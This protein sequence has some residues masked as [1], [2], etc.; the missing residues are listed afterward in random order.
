MR[1]N[2]GTGIF[3]TCL[4]CAL[5][6]SEGLTALQRSALLRAPALLRQ[7]TA[8]PWGRT[9]A[10][11]LRADAASLPAEDAPAPAVEAPSGGTSGMAASTFNVI[12]NIVGAGMLSLPAGVAAFTDNT[13]GLLPATVLT[14]IFGAVSAY[15][16]SVLG[17]VTKLNNADSYEDAWARAVSPNSAWIVT[18]ACTLTCLFSCL[19]YGLII[20]DSFTPFAKELGLPALLASR[21]GVI[22]GLTLTVLTPLCLLKDLSALAFTSVLGVAGT[23][24]STIAIMAR[25]FDGSYAP[26]AP[27][28]AALAASG[29]PTPSFD[30]RGGSVLSAKAFV[31]LSMLGTAYNAHFN[32]PRFF[33][34]LK[35]NTQKR[36][37]KVVW[38]SFYVSSAIYAAV[39]I[40]GF[41]TFGGSSLG[42]L[43]NNYA[44]NDAL[45]GVGR[46]AIGASILFT[47]PLTFVGARD[48]ILSAVTK[49]KPATEG[50][51]IGTS[52]AILAALTALACKITDVGVVVSFGGAVL[53][54]AIIYIFPALI[55]LGTQRAQL[56]N[57]D[58]DLGT[59][60][61]GRFSLLGNYALVGMGAAL[62]IIGGAVSILA[63]RGAL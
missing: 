30:V 52:L 43:L 50:Q 61:W 39:M 31:L 60:R 19:A 15:T 54:S 37:D 57:G 25:A 62:G 23:I 58:L 49:G 7:R 4:L 27:L 17:K 1:A 12:K 41:L 35:D 11:P 59:S 22:I 56:R 42:Y 26:G 16:F 55:H 32:A 10:G 13:S 53:G 2:T 20:G 14:L 46:L 38:R 18:A 8:A 9:A 33:L 36:F 3:I 63:A 28:I 5:C 40:C 21:Q 6:R 29:A 34:Q 48:G 44:Q 47:Y 51:R 45:I 24:Y